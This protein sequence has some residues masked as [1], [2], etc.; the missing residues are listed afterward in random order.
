M[1]GPVLKMSY[2]RRLKTGLVLALN[3]VF[4]A[5]YPVEKLRGIHVSIEYPIESQHYPSI[6]VDFEDSV[7]QNAGIDHSEEDEGG[8]RFLRW[9]F[10]GHVSFTIA[11]LTS[12][13]RDTI[14]D[15][16]VKVLAFGRSSDALNA[17]REFI[18]NNEYIAMNIDF[19]EIQVG[20]NAATPGTPWETD[21]IIYEST[22]TMEVLGEFRTDVDTGDLVPLSRIVIDG[23]TM[24]S[25]EDAPAGPLHWQVPA[26]GLG[27]GD[28]H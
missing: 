19:D 14:F 8:G 24:P 1:E 17:F 11:S 21:E 25:T 4:D 15:E 10:E 9:R 3:K 23:R 13:E 28:W 2:R 5:N 20:G 16:L 18:E 22:V 6:W 26:Q 12:L 27:S 7:L